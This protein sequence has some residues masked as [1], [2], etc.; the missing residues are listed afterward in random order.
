[1]SQK[2]FIANVT[3]QVIERHVVRGL[4][5]IFSPIFVNK[6]DVDEIEGFASEPAATKRQRAFLE[7][8]IG[9]LQ[10]GHAVL[11]RVMHTAS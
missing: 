9:K 3:T 4:E 1:M 5:D 8:R 2:T 10:E 6:L 7:D 11:R